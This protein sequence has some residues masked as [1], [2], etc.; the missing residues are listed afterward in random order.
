MGQVFH[1]TLIERGTTEYAEAESL[2][3]RC[4]YEP[5]GLP[6]E[7]VDA[8]DGPFVHVIAVSGERAVGYGRL[9]LD[10]EGARASQAVVAEERRGEGIGRAIMARLAELAAEWG[11][12]DVALDARDYAVGF[13]ERLGYSAEGD[14]FIRGQT[15]IP[16]KT[17]RLRLG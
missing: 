4:L 12:P 14:W 13:Y 5:W 15:G 3:Y 2:R 9:L 11:S 8:G 17:M 16:H 1:I 10:S 7:L 6:R